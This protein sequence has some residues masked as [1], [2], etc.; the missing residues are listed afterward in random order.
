MPEIWWRADD[1]RYANWDPWS[2][3]DYTGSHLKIE[4]T[5]VNVLRHTPKGVILED[6][7]FQRGNAI[8]QNAVPT[9]EL[10]LMDLVA[11]KKR[12]V[13]G[14]AYRL[15]EAKEHLEGAES[16]LHHERRNQDPSHSDL[17]M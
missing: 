12:H 6:Y 1:K 17:G 5:P 13:Q 7:G 9:K 3:N 14:A 8:R 10:A 2:D 4:L 11:R 16:A 15:T